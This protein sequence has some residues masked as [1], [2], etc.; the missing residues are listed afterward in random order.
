MERLTLL[1]I[2]VDCRFGNPKVACRQGRRDVAES[3]I[4]GLRPKDFWEIYEAENPLAE[5]LRKIAAI[6][7]EGPTDGVLLAV[8]DWEAPGL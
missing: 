2:F 6:E 5:A 8:E 4:L 7:R 3:T 1:Q